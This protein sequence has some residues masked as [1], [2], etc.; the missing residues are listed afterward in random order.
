MARLLDLVARLQAALKHSV[1]VAHVQPNKLLNNA[2]RHQ[3][4]WG[5]KGGRRPNTNKAGQEVLAAHMSSPAKGSQTCTARRAKVLAQTCSGPP[6]LLQ[7]SGPSMTT[8]RTPSSLARSKMKRL[9][10]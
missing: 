1:C 10:E 5:G 2:L 9:E 4:L 8:L 6:T 3:V 7:E